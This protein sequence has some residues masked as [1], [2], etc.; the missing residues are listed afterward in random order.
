MGAAK[1]ALKLGP[2][3]FLQLSE[4][5]WVWGSDGGGAAERDPGLAAGAAEVGGDFDHVDLDWAGGWG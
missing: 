5:L 1:M 2:D 3:K 4:G